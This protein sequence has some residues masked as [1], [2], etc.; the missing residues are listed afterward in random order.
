MLP[1]E[2]IAFAGLKYGLFAGI[3]NSF[4]SGS[5]TDIK[6]ARKTPASKQASKVS[7]A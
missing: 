7:R 1:A 5:Q 6:A 2:F 3:G 4:K